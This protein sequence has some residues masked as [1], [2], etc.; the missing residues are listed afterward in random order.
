MAG[1][2]D[3]FLNYAV[4]ILIITFF[5]FTIYKGVKEPADQFFRWIGTK[6][7]NM[8]SGAEQEYGNVIVYD[9]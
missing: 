4:P 2:L 7:S 5:A 6:I 1:G 3:S 8:G 9:R